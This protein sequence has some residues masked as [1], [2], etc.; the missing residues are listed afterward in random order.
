MSGA[1]V[2]PSVQT[3]NATPVGDRSANPTSLSVETRSSLSVPGRAPDPARPASMT[4]AVAPSTPPMAR[5]AGMTPIL[6][7]AAGSTPTSA[8]VS[9]IR[10]NGG[11][12]GSKPEP[13]SS[14]ESAKVQITSRPAGA[15]PTATG[16]AAMRSGSGKPAGE[17]ETRSGTSG[18]RVQITARASGTSPTASGVAAVRSGQARSGE[19]PGGVRSVEQ[20]R[21]RPPL[22]AESIVGERMGRLLG[23]PS[24]PGVPATVGGAVAGSGMMHLSSLDQ[25]MPTVFEPGTPHYYGIATHHGG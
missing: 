3:K 10:G 24:M 5:P 2:S 16:L 9:A 17:M 6:A 18:G 22:A 20:I 12:T 15:S 7:R 8:G 19:S 13:R 25:M 21:G 14:S 11:V 1:V 4:S 23:T